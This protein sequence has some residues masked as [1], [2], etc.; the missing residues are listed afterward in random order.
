MKTLCHRQWCRGKLRFGGT[1]PFSAP[2]GGTLQHH[3][4]PETSYLGGTAFPLDNIWG[5]GGPPHSLSTCTESPL[6]HCLL[7]STSFRVFLLLHR[8]MPF[9]KTLLVQV[10]YLSSNGVI[11]AVLFAVL[12]VDYL[13]SHIS[14]SISLGGKDSQQETKKVENH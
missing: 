4:S 8:I 5:N 14:A 10:K 3:R 9:I 6:H 12:N 1:L 7:R 13:H 11:V 2:F